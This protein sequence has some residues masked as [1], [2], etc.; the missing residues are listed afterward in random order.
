MHWTIRKVELHEV[1]VCTFPA[2]EA[3]N[4]QARSQERDALR[5]RELDAWKAKQMEVLRKWH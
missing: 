3:T 2:Y 4:V 1:S 5:K